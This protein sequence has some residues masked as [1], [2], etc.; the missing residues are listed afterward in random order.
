MNTM[1]FIFLMGLL[2]SLGHCVG[3]CSAVV[4]VLE[5]QAAFRDRPQSW[6]LAHLGRINAYAVL[7]AVAGAF[8]GAMQGLDWQPLQG[9]LSIIG[10][11]MALYFA[12]AFLGWVPAADLLLA[13][14]TRKWSQGMRRLGMG[15]TPFVIGLLWGLLPCGMVFSA[16]LAAAALGQGPLFGGLSLALF[17]LGTLPALFG[18]RLFSAPLNRRAW[19]RQSMALL[20]ALF[21]VQLALRGLAVWGVVEHFAL[22]N[23]MLW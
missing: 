3:M 17:G 2:G 11:L 23:L 4:F 10:G 9:I 21:G 15:G 16:L 22:A 13:P 8:G 12:A 19:P 1:V 7:G 6:A 5:R 14:I 18:L 20:M